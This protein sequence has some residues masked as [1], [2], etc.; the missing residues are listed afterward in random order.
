MTWTSSSPSVANVSDSGL[1]T[2]VAAGSTNITA[3]MAN[4]SGS[5]LLTVTPIL[6][7]ISVTPT[8]SSMVINSTLEYTATGI[9]SDG[10]AQDLSGQVTWSS[11]DTTIASIDAVGVATAIASGSTTINAT[12]GTISGTTGLTVTAPVLSSINVS[13]DQPSIPLG[14]TQAFSATG[15]FSDGSS[16]NL[17]AVTWSS[18]DPAVATIDNSGIATTVGTGAV[19][20]TAL[21]GS[22][23]GTTILTVLPAA[24][25][26]I[27]FIPPSPSLALGTSTQMA[28]VGLFTDGSTQTLSS[29]TWTS[30]DPN[31]ATIDS[32]GLVI[33]VG[34]GSVTISANTATISSSKTVTITNAVLTAIAVSPNNATVPAGVPQQFTATGT[35]SDGS[36]QD[37]TSTVTWISSDG[38]VATISNSG[39]ANGAAPGS[40]T[41]SASLASLSRSASLVVTSAVLQ[42]I[43]VTP[44]NP[45][46]AVGTTVQLTATGSYSDGSTQDVTSVAGWA[47]SIGG[48]ASIDVAGLVTARKIGTATVSATVGT[49]TG[50]VTVTVSGHIVQ[51]IVVTPA[52]PSVTS[53]SKFQFTAT[54]FFDDGTSQD[55]TASAHWS[56]SS[57]NL[58]T[59]NSGQNG[60][61]L[62][63]AKAVGNVTITATLNGVSGTTTMTIN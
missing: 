30:S 6:S 54:A 55:I 16:A 51:S 45:T 35:F 2:A 27:S 61:G 37:I 7:S 21:S 53:G 14:L 20:I 12:L 42:S 62:A 10:S 39:L 48:V 15:L 59:I 28:A 26:S 47:S 49:V 58:A 52:N 44:V 40:A 18:S 46:L 60:G 33:S 5:K 13:P 1:A 36:S 4:V 38:T 25:V 43:T 29:V 9:W 50:S 3:T 63:T 41:I 34:L 19:T 56:T 23:T 8:N 32:T 17:A 31:I 22:V 11:S 57:A 24:L